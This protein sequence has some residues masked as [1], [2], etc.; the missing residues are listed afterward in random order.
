MAEFEWYLRLLQ[1]CQ[2][3]KDVAGVKWLVSHNLIKT[4]S[5][6][7][8]ARDRLKAGTFQEWAAPLLR[9]KKP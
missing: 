6:F 9:P 4:A 7:R 3:T 5:D 8:E 1:A 2:G